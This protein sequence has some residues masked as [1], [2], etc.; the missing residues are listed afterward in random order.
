MTHQRIVQIIALAV[1]LAS[2]G[3]SGFVAAELTASVGR[4]KLAY[5]DRAEEGDPPQVAIGIAMGAFR[6]IFVNFLWIRANALK[7]AGKHYEANNLARAITALQPRFPR[8]WGFHAWNMAYNI[9]VATQTPDER[10]E[11]VKKGINL[12]RDEGVKYNPNDLLIHKEL[13]WIFLHKVGGY[14]DDANQYYKRELAAEWTFVLGEPPPPS[15]NLAEEEA[16]LERWADWF[17][18]IVDAPERLS[19]LTEQMPEVQALV[20]ELAEKVDLQPDAGLLRAFAIQDA[21]RGSGREEVVRKTMTPRAAAL[22]ELMDDDA[23]ADAWPAL[24]AHVRKRVLKD[25]YNM[26]P[27]RMVRYM[28]AYGP[29]D[30]RHPAAHALYWTAKGVEESLNRKAVYNRKDF[31]YI[32]TD[33]IAV[34]AVQE[35][36]RSGE[37]FFDIL[38]YADG[39]GYVSYLAI[40]NPYFIDTYAKIVEEARERSWADQEQRI[41]SIYSAGYENFLQDSIRFLYRRGQRA[42][43]EEYLDKLITYEKQNI[44]NPVEAAERALLTLDEFI[45]EQFEADRY[46][47][48]NVALEEFYGS[49]QGAFAHG[50]IAGNT[51]AFESQMRYASDFYRAYTEAQVRET[52]VGSSGSGGPRMGIFPRPFQLAA[53][54]FFGQFLSAV[55]LEEAEQAYD[56]APPWLQRY[57][58]DIMF[59]RW[60]PAIDAQEEE[61]GRPFAEIFIEPPDMTAWR[62]RTQEQLERMGQRRVEDID[63]Q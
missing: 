39:D 28:R 18:P 49:L 24:I 47:V 3:A 8:V 36:R 20:D 40:P 48:P 14:T 41:Y 23:Y 60:K 54:L 15:V 19:T 9:S 29:M 55:G 59:D 32:N 52:A 46:K 37:I 51:E 35:L 2:F 5:T 6:G 56:N 45:E 53:G 31:D 62:Q 10:W 63:Q 21:L 4:N 11:W 61:G 13:G 16:V 38:D 30:W 12:L 43:A 22:A 57:A 26:E 42:K 7:E 44:N 33:R 17:Q 1:A 50:L 58:Y 25:K 34:Q 27:S